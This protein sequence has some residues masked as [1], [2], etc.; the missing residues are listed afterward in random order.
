MLLAI[1]TSTA[2][3]G[4]AL[5]DGA[6]RAELTW[7]AGREHSSQV[8]PEAERLLGRLGLR[9]GDLSAVAV[10]RGPGSF[11]GV[12]VGLALA[13]GLGFALGIPV[14]GVCTLDVLAAAQEA[15]DLPIRP[16]VDA[17]RGRFATARYEWQ[18]G[19][20]VRTSDILGTDLPGLAAL[21]VRPEWLCGDLD[22]QQR[23]WIATN[24]GPRA[25]LASPA[26]SLRRPGFL[27]QLGWQALQ[28]GAPG[29]P[30]AVDALYLGGPA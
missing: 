3:A 14:V 27:A 1:D 6:L 13:K 17:G 15:T 30:S 7:R 5:Y 11:T 28:A 19:A 18:G 10:A 2:T 24:L 16:L 29:D 8:M 4:L 9:A 21:V 20:L 12:R 23:A 25:R 22:A 26:A